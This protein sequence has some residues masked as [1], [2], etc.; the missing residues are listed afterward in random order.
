[1]LLIS[2]LK[3]YRFLYQAVDYSARPRC[4]GYIRYQSIFSSAYS[5]TQETDKVL[6]RDDENDESYSLLINRLGQQNIDITVNLSSEFRE[7]DDQN[8]VSENLHP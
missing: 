8:V 4:L 2:R 7:R 5:R 6:I 3:R 1:M